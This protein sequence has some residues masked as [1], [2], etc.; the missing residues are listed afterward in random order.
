MSY[1]D[2]I[3]RSYPLVLIACD[4]LTVEPSKIFPEHRFLWVQP[5]VKNSCMTYPRHLQA[6]DGEIELLQLVLIRLLETIL[7]L[8]ILC[9]R[10]ELWMI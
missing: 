8:L 2:I 4:A 1:T 9:G 6:I 3:K 5:T 10:E 7:D